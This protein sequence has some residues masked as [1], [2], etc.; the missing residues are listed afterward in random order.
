MLVARLQP[1]NADENSNQQILRRLLASFTIISL[2]DLTVDYCC[3]D[4]LL[5]LLYQ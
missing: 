4:C 2:T 1:S 3:F 5:L